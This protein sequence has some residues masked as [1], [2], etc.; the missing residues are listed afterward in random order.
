MWNVRDKSHVEG[1]H[2]S[3]VK[4][5]ECGQASTECDLSEQM[6]K[7]DVERALSAMLVHAATHS[8]YYQRLAWAKSV[9]GGARVGLKN[10]PVTG[11]SIVRDETEQFYSDDVP[12]SEGKVEINATSGSTGEPMALR[13]THRF[14]WINEL[15]R[16]R[17]LKEWNIEGYS[18]AARITNPKPGQ[19]PGSIKQRGHL[20][21]LHTVDIREA[22]EFVKETGAP[23]LFAHPAITVGMLQHGADIGVRLPLKLVSTVSEIIPE[24]LLDLISAM[25]GCR[26]A[27]RYANAENGLMA[28]QCARCGAYHPAASH[29]VLEILDDNDRAVRPGKMGRVV[30]TSLFN[31]AMPLVRYETGDYAVVAKNHECPRSS[32]SLASIAGREKNLFKM[33]NGDRIVPRLSPLSI[34]ELGLR[35]CKLVQRTLTDIEFQY[36]PKDPTNEL[37]RERAQA[38]VE[39]F[40]GSGFEVTCRRVSEMPRTARGKFLMHE[41]LV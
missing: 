17:L 2:P 35:H 31:R 38:L 14:L 27:D 33:P 9:R 21:S 32:L 11:K 23:M 16:D 5:A 12:Q 22:F 36:V 3:T 15:E 20:R 13:Q 7:P 1:L 29:L 18:R 34:V 10:I 19:P 37:P 4:A 41:S 6:Y 8:P 39:E 25:P 40:M 24:Q 28:M 30:V 26:L